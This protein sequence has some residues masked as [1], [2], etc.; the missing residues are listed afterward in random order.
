M[1]VTTDTTIYHLQVNSRHNVTNTLY[2]YQDRAAKSSISL[3]KEMKGDKGHPNAVI[4]HHII[5]RKFY[6]H[7]FFHKRITELT[8]P[9]LENTSASFCS[10][11]CKATRRNI[12]ALTQKWQG[13]KTLRLVS[14]HADQCQRRR[15]SAAHCPPYQPVGAGLPPSASPG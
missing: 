1:G 4:R 3:L 8:C 9:Q 14:S 13:K 15:R 6:H 12:T 2:Y 7:V 10:V 11:T 5:K